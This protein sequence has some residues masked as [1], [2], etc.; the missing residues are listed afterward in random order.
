MTAGEGT[1]IDALPSSMM[2]HKFNSHADPAIA[3][4]YY[5]EAR[6]RPRCGLIFKNSDVLCLRSN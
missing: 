4:R 5:L 6:G 3:L 1:G 2:K